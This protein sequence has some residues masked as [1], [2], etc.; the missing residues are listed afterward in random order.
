MKNSINQLF[1]YHFEKDTQDK[2]NTVGSIIK[3]KGL[4]NSPTREQKDLAT[5][6]KS[7]KKRYST[8]LEFY[9][10]EDMIQSYA[11]AFLFASYRLEELESLEYL[12]A[13]PE[14]Y[15]SRI[16]YIKEYINHEFHEIANPNIQKVKTRGGDKYIDNSAT[17]LDTPVGQGEDATTLVNLISDENSIFKQTESHH[18]H[19]VQ[20]FLDNRE[21]ILTKKQ[22]TTFETLKDIYQPKAGNTK[23]DNAQRQLMLQDANLNNRNM[24]LIFKRIKDRVTDAYEK[25]FDGVYHSHSYT[26]RKGLYEVMAEYIESADYPGWNTAQERQRELTGIIQDYYNVYEELEITITKGLS[27]EE[28]KEIVRGV[29]G[30]TLISHLVLRKVNNNI[31]EELSNHKPLMIEASYPEF[32][33]NENPFAGL[34]KL[35][36]SNLVITTSGTVTAKDNL[37]TS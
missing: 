7:I 29:N 34:S 31:K 20:Y 26:E 37:Q 28:K 27:L 18:N 32:E 10:T 3:M 4:M 17:S 19:F 21:Q 22:L 5:H 23:E 36:E 13:N 6:F 8:S 15:Q 30:I 33:Y 9:T 24:K 11:T 16:S 14:V 2:N 12:L 35:H 25:E 1:N